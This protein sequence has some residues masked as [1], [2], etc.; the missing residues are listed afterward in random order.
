MLVRIA[1]TFSL[2][3]FLLATVGAQN[4]TELQKRLDSTPKAKFRAELDSIAGPKDQEFRSIIRQYRAGEK[5][6]EEVRSY[7][8]LRAMNEVPAS[9]SGA[10]STVQEIKR[11]ALY[12]DSGE[13]DSANWY[14]KAI[15]KLTER[16]EKKKPEIDSSGLPGINLSW[17][18]PVVWAIL[19]GLVI[20]F[21]VYALQHVRLSMSRR[22]TVKAVL[23]EDEPD[24]TLDEWLAEADK[25]E[26]AG[27]HRE[28][29]RALYLACLL[30]F[31][32]HR[33]ARF[34]R[35]Q[36][37]WEHLARIESSSKRPEGL[38]FRV[39]TQS[40]DRIWYGMQVRGSEDV[41]QFREWYV[42]LTQ[43]LTEV[44]P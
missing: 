44:K 1:S 6:M 2:L 11:G 30:R 18:I 43:R 19:G 23:D 39:P 29:V 34:V 16:L 28:A 35:G 41:R 20:T 33:V 25:L 10:K 42:S 24:R 12:G 32:E 21:L 14:G 22:R 17:V 3:L 38:D 5:G 15:R 4:F 7:V 31:D 26:A 37:N 9:S 27:R 40:F 36:T 8:R 13:Q